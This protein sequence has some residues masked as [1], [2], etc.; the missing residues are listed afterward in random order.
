MSFEMLIILGAMLILY[1]T[2]EA[3][4]RQFPRFAVL[5]W[6]VGIKIGVDLGQ[7]GRADTT[8][9]T[10]IVL[11]SLGIFMA[12]EIFVHFVKLNTKQI[13]QEGQ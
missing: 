10:L 5:L 4:T 13:P 3:L 2:T 6:A 9:A 7:Q 1:L 8:D 12:R 11:V